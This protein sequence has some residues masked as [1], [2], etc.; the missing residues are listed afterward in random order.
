MPAAWRHFAARLATAAQPLRRPIGRQQRDARIGRTALI[1]SWAA[2]AGRGRDA[3]AQRLLDAAVPLI[4]GIPYSVNDDGLREF[5][6]WMIRTAQRIA[7]LSNWP[8]LSNRLDGAPTPPPLLVPEM[9][10]VL[11]NIRQAR[12]RASPLAIAHMLNH[13]SQ[14]C[15]RL[16]RT[17]PDLSV[18]E[19]EDI[20]QDVLAEFRAIGEGN[21]DWWRETSVEPLA[22][23][24]LS[25][26]ALEPDERSR[27]RLRQFERNL[28]RLDGVLSHASTKDRFSLESALAAAMADPN[29]LA[30][31][32]VAG[33]LASIKSFNPVRRET[34][35]DPSLPDTDEPELPDEPLDQEYSA[36]AVAVSSMTTRIIDVKPLQRTAVLLNF[37][38]APNITRG[39]TWDA[40]CVASRVEMTDQRTA[41]RPERV[42]TMGSS[43][44]SWNRKLPGW[45]RNI[46]HFLQRP[47]AI[48]DSQRIA[49]T[50]GLAAL[51][52]STLFTKDL[53]TWLIDSNAEHVYLSPHELLSQVPLHALPVHDGRFFTDLGFSVSYA[54]GTSWLEP[55]A[56]AA[57]DRNEP[58]LLVV[59]TSAPELA[60]LQERIQTFGS[61]ARFE[62]VDALFAEIRRQGRAVLLCHGLYD[63]EQLG[64]WRSR[65]LLP[66]G[67]RVT[68]R[69]LR[70]M[71]RQKTLADCELVILACQAGAVRHL[72]SN[73]GLAGA[74]LESGARSVIAPMRPIEASK[75]VEF[76]EVYLQN[77]P[78][79]STADAYSAAVMHIRI[80]GQSED[81]WRAGWTGAHTP[82]SARR[83]A[84][85]RRCN[86]VRRVTERTE[87]NWNDHA[88]QL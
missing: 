28:V 77:R 10:A 6:G 60:G 27:S 24:L 87:A 81:P 64:A 50:G 57:A 37:F 54:I 16:Q 67:A 36:P 17:R 74:F 31:E 14:L 79:V 29:T 38:L 82:C 39:P 80:K 21:P 85:T 44:Q 35:P 58:P 72:H 71:R 41:V 73:S 52:G 84:L 66:D 2:A 9:K 62:D 46:A 42:F 75:A 49:Q 32:T 53:V 86:R 7:P 8:T 43:P 61:L 48:K 18:A 68:V 56:P 51:V 4:D 5:A 40:M 63:D 88:H 65:L 13:L 3:A 19:L 78:S 26:M 1:L 47:D 20:A 15:D 22:H 11:T 25:R 12:G 55:S 23:D 69:A 83:C 70:M 76:L 30:I 33:H 59:D 34:S 45:L